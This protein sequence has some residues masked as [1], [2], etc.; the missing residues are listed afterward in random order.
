MRTTLAALSSIAVLAACVSGTSLFFLDNKTPITFTPEERAFFDKLPTDGINGYCVTVKN[1]LASY[2]TA[3]RQI[4]KAGLTKRGM[5]SHD[6][7]LIL[8]GNYGTGMTF[9]GLACL[10]GY[11][12]PVNTSFYPGIGHQWQAVLANGDYVYLEG[13]GTRGGMRVTSWN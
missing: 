13:D 8:G 5:T 2:T 3:D 4:V 12:P 9:P 6:A 11:E 10:V 1:K 7:D